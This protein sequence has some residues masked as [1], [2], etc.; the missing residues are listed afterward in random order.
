MLLRD[1]LHKCVSFHNEAV[2]LHRMG[3]SS[4]ASKLRI[5]AMSFIRSGLWGRAFCLGE[6]LQ[7]KKSGCQG[8]PVD[9]I[10]FSLKIT[11]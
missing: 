1:I 4:Q 8:E 11:I 2:R 6:A 9:T 3:S 7:S 5:I 10:P